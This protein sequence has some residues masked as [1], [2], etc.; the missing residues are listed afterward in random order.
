MLYDLEFPDHLRYLRDTESNRQDLIEK[1]G[2]QKHQ[3]FNNQ[4]YIEF[5]IN[6]KKWNSTPSFQWLYRN[7]PTLISVDEL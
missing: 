3:F 5:D 1:Y 7:Q 6:T 2:D 4:A